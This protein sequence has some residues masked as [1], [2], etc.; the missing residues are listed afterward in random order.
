MN[1]DDFD[2]EKFYL[3]KLCKRGH[4][5]NGTG[6]SLRR[7][8]GHCEKCRCEREKQYRIENKDKIKEKNHLYR[9][10][11]KDKIKQY[12][13]EN[14]DKIKEKNKDKIKQRNQRYHREHK[15]EINQRKREFYANH[16]RKDKKYLCV[17]YRERRNIRD[18]ERRIND[19]KFKINH[20]IRCAIQKSLK[21]NKQGK[22]WEHLVDYTLA[23]LKKH[24]EKKFNKKNGHTWENYG[25]W[26]IDHIIPVSIFNFTKPEHPDFKRC[27]AL[28]NLQ[29]LWGP[30]N[31]SKGAKIAQAFQPM[32]KLEMTV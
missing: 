32:L 8:L 30:E 13:I 22:H 29:P 27:W 26:H 28:S 4:D 20:N 9:N 18:R 1:A 17:E 14:K 15:E 31:M 16:K 10:K 2:T 25:E 23:D 12:R 19:L 11:N 3:G 5:W 21:S 24:L 6:K 7:K